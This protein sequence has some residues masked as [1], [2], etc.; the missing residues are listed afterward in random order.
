MHGRHGTAVQVE[1]GDFLEQ[2]SFADVDRDLRE[3]LE[4]VV[5]VF[6]PF[7]RQEE[8]TGLVPG[9]EGASQDP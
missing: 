3:L 2:R 1:S 5:E 6:Q 8:G 4:D 7:L 9:R